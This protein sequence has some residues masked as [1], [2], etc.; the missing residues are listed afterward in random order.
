MER[1][2]DESPGICLQRKAALDSGGFV[3]PPVSNKFTAGGSCSG[4]LNFWLLPGMKYSIKDLKI[5]TKQVL[6]TNRSCDPPHP[7]RL[8][9]WSL[10]HRL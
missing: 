10:F 9:R 1:F 5:N 2:M 4:N 8:G 6:F 7:Q 3:A